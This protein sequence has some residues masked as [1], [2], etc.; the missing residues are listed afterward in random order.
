M[1]EPLEPRTSFRRRARNCEGDLALSE[2]ASRCQRHTGRYRQVVAST[3]MDRAE[4]CGGQSCRFL[5][6]FERV[7]SRDK[8]GGNAAILQAQSPKTGRDLDDLKS[9]MRANRFR[10]EPVI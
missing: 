2:Q 7:G 6:A 5:S 3:R 1:V 4:A 8:K 9:I 10:P